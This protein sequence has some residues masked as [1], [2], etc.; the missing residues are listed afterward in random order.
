MVIGLFCDTLVWICY[1]H[2][3]SDSEPQ[4]QNPVRRSEIITLIEFMNSI[5]VAGANHSHHSH[6]EFHGLSN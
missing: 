6:V 2:I 3:L 1:R 5:L 4:C